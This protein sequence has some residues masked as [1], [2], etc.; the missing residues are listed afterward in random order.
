MPGGPELII[1]LVVVLV[2]FGGSQLPKLAK[3]LGKAQK[4][5]KEGMG[6]GAQSATP[7]QPPPAPP[8]AAAPPPPPPPAAPP[9]NGQ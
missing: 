9:T 5:F 8:Q 1:I 6:E 4:E 7:T 2:L 3:N